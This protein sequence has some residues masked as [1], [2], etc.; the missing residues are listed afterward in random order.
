MHILQNITCIHRIFVCQ[1]KQ[2]DAEEGYQL[3]EDQHGRKARATRSGFVTASYNQLPIPGTSAHLIVS[4]LGDLKLTPEYH[5][6]CLLVAVIS[7]PFPLKIVPLP[8]WFQDLGGWINDSLD[9]SARLHQG[10][11]INISVAGA[12]VEGAHAGN[13]CTL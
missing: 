12:G 4:F 6:P 7:R 5:P 11:G 1:L 8:G 13:H 3:Q 10:G 2:G 9:N